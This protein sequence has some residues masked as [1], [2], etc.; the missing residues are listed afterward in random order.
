MSVE[1]PISCKNLRSIQSHK[2]RF[3]QERN[4]KKIS[5]RR[6]MGGICASKIN[7]EHERV[8]VAKKLTKRYTGVAYGSALHKALR[9]A[10]KRWD[11]DLEN[12]DQEAQ[13]AR[14]R[15]TIFT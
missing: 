15:A 3:S 11:N 13:K 6:F 10:D 14:V 12:P 9:K 4:S 1:T 8:P 2:I 7:T 5:G